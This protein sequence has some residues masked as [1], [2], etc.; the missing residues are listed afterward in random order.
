MT[1]YITP[2]LVAAIAALPGLYAIW[3]GKKKEAAE[4]AD[5]YQRVAAAVG[6]RLGALE[7]EVAILRKTLSEW[8]DGIE[9]LHCQLSENG[10]T[11]VWTPPP[12]GERPTQPRRKPNAKIE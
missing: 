6:E 12:I 11:P 1:E 3:R 5:I 10:L 2:I 7:D 9:Q 8:R 4:A